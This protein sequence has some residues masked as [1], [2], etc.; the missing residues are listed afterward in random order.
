MNN[1]NLPYSKNDINKAGGILLDPTSSRQ[2]TFW[3]AEVLSSWR[4]RHSYPINTFQA[5]VR[6]KLLPIDNKA[7]VSQRLKRIPSIIDK[8]RRFNTMKLSQMQDIGGLRAVVSNLKQ[9]DALYKSYKTS[10]FQHQL[11]NEKD[12][13]SDPKSSGYRSVHLVY[14]YYRPKTPEYNGLML[15]LQIRTRLQHAWATA[16]ETMGTFIDHALKSSEGPEDWLNFFALAGSAFAHLEK[17][18]LVPGYESMTRDETYQA[19]ADKTKQLKVHEN[20]RAY[21]IAVNAIH[22][23]KRR[24]SYYLIV[25]D[26]V[27]RSVQYRAYSKERLNEATADYL[28]AEE[29]IVDG[30][31]QQAVLVSTDSV[32][33]LKRAYP[34][35]FLDTHEFLKIIKQ[36]ED[37]QLR[38]F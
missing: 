16:V 22:T 27:K 34:N 32:E 17:R 12:Y 3:A 23:D 18:K 26:P 25:L 19:V 30:S 11:I 5:T 1:N 29:Q 9:V 37:K 7:L 36:I 2:A 33:A 15:E 24:G 14:K 28:K 6:K 20:L 31:Q 8:L 38:L 21:S 13:I 35:Y 4:S 10:H